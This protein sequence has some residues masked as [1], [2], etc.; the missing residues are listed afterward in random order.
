RVN[1]GG[2]HGLEREVLAARARQVEPAGER[3]GA[4]AGDAKV[5]HRGGEARIAR[6]ADRS[7]LQEVDSRVV[8]VA[9]RSRVGTG[10]GELKDVG[11]SRQVH[12]AEEDVGRRGDR[13]V[14]VERAGGGVVQVEVGGLWVEVEADGAVVV[15][16]REVD[17]QRVVRLN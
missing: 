2:L 10:D 6:P 11:T 13:A 7:G 4:V 14:G 15:P 5:V 9:I 16:G 17:S 12:P 3:G 1:P 8:V